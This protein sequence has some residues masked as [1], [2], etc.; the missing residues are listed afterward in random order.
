MFELIKTG[1]L[2]GQTKDSLEIKETVTHKFNWRNVVQR[3]SIGALAAVF[4]R[5]TRRFLPRENLA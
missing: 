4:A 2:A 3:E 5:S 1:S